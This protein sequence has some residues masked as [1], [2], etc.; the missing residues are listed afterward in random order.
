MLSEDSA[1][2]QSAAIAAIAPQVETL[3]VT[4]QRELLRAGAAI[5][6]AEAQADIIWSTYDVFAPGAGYAFLDSL[7]SVVKPRWMHT[8]AAGFD[9]AVF[10]TLVASGAVLTNSH[11]QA[12][13]MAEFVVASVLDHFQCGPARRS[14]QARGVWERTPSR[15]IMGT[16]W[17]MLGFGA[18]GQAIATRVNVFGAI[19]SA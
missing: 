18:I 9:D 4:P 19:R 13:G 8:S 10:R 14:A 3:I 17:L 16:T 11:G 15:E 12:I 7:I 1:R 5:P 6:V 2:R